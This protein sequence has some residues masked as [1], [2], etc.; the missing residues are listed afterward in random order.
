MG[1]L[2]AIFRE[3][4]AARTEWRPSALS[5]LIDCE[6]TDVIAKLLVRVCKTNSQHH[7]SATLSDHSFV[8]C[9]WILSALATKGKDKFEICL[10]LHI[11]MGN[12]FSKSTILG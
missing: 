12:I 9:F 7:H 3:L 5:A 11:T 10:R 8:C 1:N 2:L 6:A 4:L